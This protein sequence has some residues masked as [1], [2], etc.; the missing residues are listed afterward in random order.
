MRTAGKERGRGS[1]AAVTTMYGR[2]AW[3]VGRGAW[4]V[5]RGAWNEQYWSLITISAFGQ[6]GQASP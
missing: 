1:S 5:G 2:G 6:P 3:G 4:G